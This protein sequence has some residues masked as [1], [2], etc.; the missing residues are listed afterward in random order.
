MSME[1]MIETAVSQLGYLEKATNAYLDNKTANAG[2]NNYTKYGKW[3]GLNGEP[4]CDMFVSWC[5]DQAGESAAVGKYA[6]CPS[7]VQFF[8]GKGQWFAKGAKTPQRGDI[9][10]F[11]DADHVGIVES[12]SGGYVHTIE[13]N[14]RATGYSTNGG[15]VYRK[16]YPL[17]SEYIM[18]YGRPSYSGSSATTKKPV[19]YGQ[20]GKTW[21]NGST[22]EIVFKDTDLTTKTGSLNPGESCYC[23]GRYGGAYLV[24][25]KIDGTADDWAV[26]YVAYHGG[27]SE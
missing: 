14:T 8:K 3:Y 7:H 21:K 2:Y 1:K 27:I 26:G 17:A 10:F 22:E 6:Y 25:Y 23:M 19:W 15:G 4:W 20:P 16:S 9:I 13:G 18:G 11:G 12:V 5:A 24:M